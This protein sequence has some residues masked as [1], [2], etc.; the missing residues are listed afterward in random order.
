MLGY[1][2]LPPS[3]RIK[4]DYAYIAPEQGAS[5]FIFIPKMEVY[6]KWIYYR[7]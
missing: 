4:G 2:K 3:V 6:E 1:R 5:A 7:I